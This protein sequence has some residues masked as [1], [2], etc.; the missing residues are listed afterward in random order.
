MTYG[1]VYVAQ[2]GMGADKNQL[3]KA[4]RE[5]EAYQGPSLVIAYSPC[6]AHGIAAGMGKT[7]EQTKK[8][9]E[10]GYWHLYR[11]NPELAEEGKN[12]FILDSKEPKADFKEYLMGEVRYSSLKK[13]FPETADA[14]FEKAAKDARE[15]YEIYKQLAEMGKQPV[16]AEA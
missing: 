2:V 5:A 6:I 1:Y 16:K 10:A 8:A 11:Y 14:L 12:P 7:Q 13:E 3:M 4:L 9:V 15:R